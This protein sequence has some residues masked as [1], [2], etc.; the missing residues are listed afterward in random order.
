MVWDRDRVSH[1]DRVRIIVRHKIS[2]RVRID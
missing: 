2:F 1:R